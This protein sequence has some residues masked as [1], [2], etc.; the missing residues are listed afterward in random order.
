MHLM[1]QLVF[2]KYC[3]TVFQEFLCHNREVALAERKNYW[4][5]AFIPHSCR[6]KGLQV[7]IRVHTITST[8]ITSS[9]ELQS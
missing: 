5:N 2:F 7:H 8:L 1:K 6:D 3:H 9:E 4:V